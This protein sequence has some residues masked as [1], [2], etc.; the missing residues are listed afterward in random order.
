MKVDSSPT[1]RQRRSELDG[2]DAALDFQPDWGSLPSPRQQPRRWNLANKLGLASTHPFRT[3]R[4]DSY[5]KGVSS[6]D[7]KPVRMSQRNW[8]CSKENPDNS[9]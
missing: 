8:Q 4:M 2:I 3:N 5:P 9:K 1:E 6:T 7:V